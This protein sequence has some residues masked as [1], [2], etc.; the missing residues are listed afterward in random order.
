MAR[1]SL[2]SIIK[3]GDLIE[4]KKAVHR[5]DN[6]EEKDSQGWTPLF[7]AA[8]IGSL[9]MVRC[10]LSAGASVNDGVESG[11]TA[12]FSAVMSDHVT[13]V[14]ELLR[15]GAKVAPVQGIELRMYA[16]SEEVRE[17]LD[18]RS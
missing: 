5:G 14:R 2:I 10:L 7:H 3:H 12:L 15:S 13:V 1:N 11:F 9:P 6:L 18:K 4:L 16:K 8:G 17:L